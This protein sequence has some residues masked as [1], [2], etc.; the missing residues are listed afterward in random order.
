MP[1]RC[2]YPGSLVC[3][4]QIKDTHDACL[5]THLN[6]VVCP[7]QLELLTNQLRA[8]PPQEWKKGAESRA[9]CR[10][11]TSLRAMAAT[12]IGRCGQ[13]S[14]GSRTKP[15][16]PGQTQCQCRPTRPTPG[17]RPANATGA[18]MATSRYLQPAQHRSNDIHSHDALRRTR[19]ADDSSWLCLR[20]HAS[21]AC[22]E[23]MAVQ[24]AADFIQHGGGCAFC[25][26]ASLDCRDLGPDPVRTD[27]P[28]QD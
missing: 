11:R 18:A 21:R 6:C 24:D 28:G 14:H 27:L 26:V 17:N 16:P 10:L 8:V 12:P 1:E 3:L 9:A 5:S 13:R 20:L 15:I 22:R 4:D 2:W 19:V 23:R 7:H 25:F